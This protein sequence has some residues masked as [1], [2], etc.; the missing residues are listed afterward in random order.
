VK[1][2]EVISDTDLE[3][4]I[5]ERKNDGAFSCTCPRPK[6]CKHILFIK[7]SEPIDIAKTRSTKPKTVFLLQTRR[8]IRLRD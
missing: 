8:Q 5:V 6:P 4:F 2:W 7:G 1:R 3:A